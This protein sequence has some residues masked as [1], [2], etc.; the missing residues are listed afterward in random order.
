VPGFDQRIH[1]TGEPARDQDARQ[2]GVN[3]RGS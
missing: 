3:A 1:P 2:P